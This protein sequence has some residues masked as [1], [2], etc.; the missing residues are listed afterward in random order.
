MSEEAMSDNTTAGYYGDA[1]VE[2]LEELNNQKAARIVELE[3]REEA[4]AKKI[5]EQLQRIEELE[6][7]LMDVKHL[8]DP[9]I[10]RARCALECKS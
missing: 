5:R 1:L 3:V 9:I 7:A 8:T 4:E 6:Q 2:R 10:E